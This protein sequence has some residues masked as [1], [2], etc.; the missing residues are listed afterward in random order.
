MNKIRLRNLGVVGVFV[1]L[2]LIYFEY[3]SSRLFKVNTEP[4]FVIAQVEDLNEGAEAESE[5]P[6]KRLEYEM[7]MLKDPSTGKIPFDIRHKELS[8]VRALNQT[9][10]NNIRSSAAGVSQTNA[11]P[12]VNFGPFNIG[13]RTRALAIDVTDENIFLAGGISGG[14]WRSTNQGTS[15][16]RTTNFDQIPSVTTIV[17]DKRTGKTAN[18]YYATGENIGNSVSETGAF[19]LGDGIYKST[20]GGVSWSLI[21][22]TAINSATSLGKFSLVNKLAIDYSNQTE[23]E[24]YVAGLSKIYRTVNDFQSVTTVLGLSNTGVGNSA[25]IA[26]ASDGTIIASIP[27]K[28][29]NGSNA[30]EGIF[31]SSD[32]ISWTSITL[33]AAWPATFR[34]VELAFDPH[35]NNFFYAL[36]ESFFYKYD[37]STSTWTALTS[38]IN[39]NSESVEGFDG[40]GGYNL[41]VAVH[42][43]N[44]NTVFIG[45]TNLLRSPNGF[46]LE[47]DRKHIGGYTGTGTAGP[48][49]NHHP[50][51]H[52]LSFLPSDPKKMF[53]GSDGGVHRTNDNIA[54][55]VVWTSLNNGYVTSQFYTVDLYRDDRGDNQIIGGMQ[56]NGTWAIFQNNPIGVWIQAYGGDGAY[57]A[58]SY[59]SLYASAQ[60]GQMGRFELVDNTYQASEDIAPSDD[61]DEF[62]FINPF[63]VD[64]VN[65][66]RL[67]VGAKGKIYYTYDIRENPGKGEWEQINGT[68]ITSQ[69]VAAMATS[70]QPEGV[71]YFG[72]TTGRLQ[73]I[74]NTKEI[75]SVENISGSNLPQGASVTSIAVDPRNANRVFVTFGNYGVISIWM[76]EDGGGTW[77]SISGNL[78]ENANGSGNGPSVR[79]IEILPNGASGEKMFVGTSTGLY[80]TSSLNGASTVWT[81][82]APSII[83]NSIVNM[84][85]VRP[86]DGKVIAATH[87]SGVFVGYYDTGFNP[88]IN[89]SMTGESSAVLRANQSFNQGQ[90]FAFKWFKDG[91]VLAG[92]TGAELIVN[93]NGTYKCEVTDQLGPVAFTNEVTF[94]FDVVAGIDDDPIQTSAQVSPNP[95]NGVFN[96]NLDAA[97][98]TGFDYSIVNSNGNQVITGKKEFYN[99]EER[100][101]VNLSTMPDGLYI[102]NINNDKRRDVI[103]LLKQRN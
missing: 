80:M 79:S 72:T 68:G 95:S 10:R 43:G 16:T 35:D 89:Y 1:V 97:Y 6:L 36:G 30:E 51:I 58:I 7:D 65:Q 5:N 62:L 60:E 71:L 55:T 32:G 37:R 57:S 23:T 41:E 9:D 99:T 66:D 24:L 49:E 13:G 102:L 31:I 92:Q 63:I 19:Y 54:S 29:S 84:V 78:E 27:N 86:I 53:S 70:V 38:N 93:A 52:T 17:Q 47:T 74:A 101:R 56:D 81:Q 39:V 12:F 61:S 3:Q 42:P 90:G 91:T 8:Y 59:N 69:P 94:N 82:Q 100:F 26:I 75:T 33:P 28:S 64:R 67:Y 22:G 11:S 103:K 87:G 2:F 4:Q 44:Q 76:S 15:W 40:Q 77:S 83:G 98:A 73:K 14:V 85:K 96:I 45:G 48:Y 20:N 50:D 46:T 18:W 88:E 34:R 25:D 21:T